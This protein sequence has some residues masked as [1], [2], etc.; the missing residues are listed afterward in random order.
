MKLLKKLIFTVCIGAMAQTAFGQH[1]H[2]N[3][4]AQDT[5]SSGAINAGDKLK[6]YFE[7][8]TQT[9]LLAYNAGTTSYGADGYNWNGYTTL[10]AY[11][12]SNPSPEDA[13]SNP[14]GALKGSFLVLN[15]VSITGTVG[16]K[17]AFYDAA[18]MDPTWVYQIGTGIISGAGSIQLTESIWFDEVADPYGHIHGR[19]FAVDMP[20]EYIATWT[21]HDTETAITGLLDS[22]TFTANYSAIP[23]PSTYALLAA[24]TLAVMIGIRRRRKITNL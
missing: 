16:A 8:G 4:G 20:G 22:D 2:I 11:H 1:G 9:S 7:P 17:F 23:E 18:A 6:M 15:L 21:L 14:N 12:Q 5:N 10:T 19:M 13:D 3:A 24:G